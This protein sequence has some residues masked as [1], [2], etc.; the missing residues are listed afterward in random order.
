[1]HDLK[2]ITGKHIKI[3]QLNSFFSNV[4]AMLLEHFDLPEYENVVFILGGYIF[5]PVSFFRDK[6]PNHKLIAYQLE[7]MMGPDN[8]NSLTRTIENLRGFDEIWDYDNLNSGFLIH[9][10]IYTDKIVPM[11][12]TQSLEKIVSKEEPKIDVLFFGTMNERRWR[13]IDTIQRRSY[14]ELKVVWS[15]G[16]YDVDEYIANSKTILNLHAFEPWNRQE[17]VRMFYPIINGKTVISEVSQVN[18]MQGLII[19]FENQNLVEV[20]RSVCMTDLWKTFGE[21][22]KKEFKERTEKIKATL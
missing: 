21:F 22:S 9:Q 3:C 19:E 16:D 18:R 1:M 12:Y 8:W 13:I 17:Q 5:H 7:Q 14:N 11:L 15:Y 2:T 10:N 20:L 4:S 6:F